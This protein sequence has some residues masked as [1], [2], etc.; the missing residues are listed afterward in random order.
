MQEFVPGF[1]KEDFW[2]I[3]QT[4]SA[5]YSL[6]N[7]KEASK[8]WQTT[9]TP[10]ETF[11]DMVY[12]HGKNTEIGVQYG[13]DLGNSKMDQTFALQPEVT[14]DQEL[15]RIEGYISRADNPQLLA[16][17]LINEG[18][19]LVVR[20]N[21]YTEDRARFTNSLVGVESAEDVAERI[22]QTHYD[23]IRR[24]VREKVAKSDPGSLVSQFH[25]I[26]GSIDHAAFDHAA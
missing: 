25:Q 3:V 19:Y 8:M 10:L 26:Y 2:P 9:S 12:W 7:M 1:T 23:L 14:N 18:K 11:R 13:I 4:E 16:D 15:R 22:S 6:I 21:N 5:S 20:Q 24:T 17:I